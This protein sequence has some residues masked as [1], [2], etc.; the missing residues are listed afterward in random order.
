[1]QWAQLAMM[2][3]GNEQSSKLS[4]QQLELL[5]KQLADIS[6]IELPK[7]EEQKADQLGESA[8]A[9]MRSDEGLRGKQ[10]QALAEIQ[11]AIDNGGLDMGDRAALEEAMGVATNQQKRARAGVAADAAARGQ[12]NSGNRLMMDMDAAQKGSNDARQSGLQTAAMAQRRKLQMIQ[13]SARMAGGLR[14]TDWREKEASARAKDIRDERNAAAREKAQYYNAGLPQQNF[15]NAMAKA[16]GKLPA[17]NAYAGGLGA[18]AAD[19]RGEYAGYAG[20]LGAYP[21]ST[22]DGDG[23][24]TNYRYDY[25]PQSGTKLTDDD[26]ETK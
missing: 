16:T 22:G 12:L 13:D 5:G 24:G 2:F 8:V 1:M 9:V 19:K 15:S 18:A 7:L 25:D 3:L 20:V 14:E 26:G 4:Q 10:L 6:G 21:N 23:G 11:N 17:A